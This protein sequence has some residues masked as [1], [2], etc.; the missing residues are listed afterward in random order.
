MNKSSI[1]SAN[2]A[3]SNMNLPYS[4]WKE[5]T[6]EQRIVAREGVFAEFNDSGRG[7]DP[8]DWNAAHNM[9]DRALFTT[10]QD[11]FEDGEW[12]YNDKKERDQMQELQKMGIVDQ[13]IAID[14]VQK[15]ND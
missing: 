13:L 14:T 10:L 5:L 4:R 6:K 15:V 1:P 12:G 8:D 9:P 2:F 3:T 11:R 7:F